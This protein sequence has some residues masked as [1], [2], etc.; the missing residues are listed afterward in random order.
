[1]RLIIILIIILFS[2]LIR[3]STLAYENKI[4]LKINNEIITTV[5]ILDEISYLK[6]LNKNIDNL[7]NEKIFTIAR[8]SLIKYKIKEIALKQIVQKFEIKDEDYNR[9]LIS[10]YSNAGYTNI[11][12]LL[13]Y[14]KNFGIK[15][16]F[17]RNKM[18]INAIWN[19]FIYDKY[20]NNIKIDYDKLKNDILKNENQNEYLL[21]EIVFNLKDNQTL[22]EKFEIIKAAIEKN[23]FENSALIYSISETS[24]NGGNIGWISE[25]SINKK[26]LEKISIIN[27]NEYTDPMIIPGGYLILKLKEKKIS[28]RNLD[29][30]KELNKIVRSKTNEILNQFSNIFL[31]KFKK[32]VIINEL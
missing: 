5:D 7:D 18:T 30:D 21:S 27:V 12:E 22:N 9:I 28:K 11:N 8:N 19:Q 3:Y 13:T 26:I 15:P 4:L 31:N 14:L 23:G 20:S 25:N 24:K 10:T 17:I 32:G 1:M 29:I 16:D 2:T 6:S